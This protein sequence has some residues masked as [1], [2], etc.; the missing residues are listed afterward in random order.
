MMQGNPSVTAAEAQEK[1]F[2]NYIMMKHE[3]I[4]LQTTYNIHQHK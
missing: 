3:E 2:L 4:Q 1:N